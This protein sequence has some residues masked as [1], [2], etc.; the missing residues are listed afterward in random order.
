[1][2]G[3]EPTGLLWRAPA[4][5]SVSGPEGWAP[6]EQVDVHHR[7]GDALVRVET[8]PVDPEADLD[9]LAAAHFTGG[10]HVVKDSGL[11]PAVVLG[12]PDGRSRS[13]TMTGVDGTG[14]QTKLEYAVR[15]GRFF[16]VTSVVPASDARKAEEAAAIVGSV[17][18][19][20][21]ADI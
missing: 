4:R 15:Q 18:V 13:V 2:A 10:E 19:S 12:S 3:T 8:W 5:V 21:P 17:S 11:G 14:I 9:Q 20:A 1:M 6:A 16:A 7:D